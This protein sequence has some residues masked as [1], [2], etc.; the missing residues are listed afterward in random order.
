MD[1]TSNPIESAIKYAE[2]RKLDT[3]KR[4]IIY[5]SQPKHFLWCSEDVWQNG[6]SKLAVGQRGTV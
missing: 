2:A 6:Q 3:G 5:E 4:Q 1:N